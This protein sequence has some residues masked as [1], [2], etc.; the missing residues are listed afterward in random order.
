MNNEVLF[1]QKLGELLMFCQC[2][3]HDVKIIYATMLIG[4]YEENYSSLEK[5]SLGTMVKLLENLDK[6]DTDL[7]LSEENYRILY[8]ITDER[9]YWVHSV[10]TE[11]V[12]IQD[13]TQRNKVFIKKVNRLDNFYGRMSKLHQ[14][15]EKLRIQLCN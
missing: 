12:Y 7:W 10:Y 2:I 9:N 13:Y 3:E 15:I 4:D 5:K 6:E 8:S 1:Y 14:K 11:Y